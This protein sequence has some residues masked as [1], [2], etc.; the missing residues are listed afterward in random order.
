MNVKICGITRAEDAVLATELGATAIGMVFW[1]SSPRYIDPEHARTIVEALPQH[2]TVVGVF[3]NQT[4]EALGI[5]RRIGLDA[6]QLHGNEP[7]DD[8]FDL[9]VPVIKAVPVRDTRSVTEASAIPKHVAVLLDAYDPVRRGGTGTVADWS[10]AAAISRRRPVLLS[11]GLNPGNIADAIAAVRPNAVDV[12]SGVES[13]PGRKD[14][15]KL[16]ALFA[17][18]SGVHET[19]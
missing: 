13:E 19:S 15:A 1:P 4:M 6:V 12:S 3:V 10:I 18:L 2:V 14:P 16:Q 17:A 11:G 9:P 7:V 8:Y 5:A